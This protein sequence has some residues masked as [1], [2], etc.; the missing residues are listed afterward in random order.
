MRGSGVRDDVNEA[1]PNAPGPDDRLG[2]LIVWL[3]IDLRR[4]VVQ[5]L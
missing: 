5:Y 4:V 3:P 2:V 1:N